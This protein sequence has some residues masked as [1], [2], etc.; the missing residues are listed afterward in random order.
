MCALGMIAIVLTTTY[1]YESVMFKFSKQ[2]FRMK[3]FYTILGMY[4]YV[5]ANNLKVLLNIF[6]LN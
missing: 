3:L 4:I 1:M 5:F 2:H 6:Y